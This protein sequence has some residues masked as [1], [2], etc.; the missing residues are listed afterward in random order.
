MFS[1]SFMEWLANQQLPGNSS[2]NKTPT[3]LNIS[4]EFE[5]LQKQV[6][7]L[8]YTFSDQEQGAKHFLNIGLSILKKIPNSISIAE[9][10]L[11]LITSESLAY[12][13]AVDLKGID[14][15][16]NQINQS[17]NRSTVSFSPISEAIRTYIHPKINGIIR[18]S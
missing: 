10:I 8:I 9:L 7:N 11:K 1:Q 3:A 18:R 4:K 12:Y 5:N 6:I 13:F 15:L 2:N 17:S 16:F 14:F